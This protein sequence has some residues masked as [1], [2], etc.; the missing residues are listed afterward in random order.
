M[1]VKHLLCDKLIS[2]VDFFLRNAPISYIY[3][4]SFIP[5]AVRLFCN[6]VLCNTAAVSVTLI[7]SYLHY[8]TRLYKLCLLIV[9]LHVSMQLHLFMFIHIIITSI[10]K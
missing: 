9:Q 10:I 5:M 7:T 8:A 3:C 1:H 2:H 6:N 4:R